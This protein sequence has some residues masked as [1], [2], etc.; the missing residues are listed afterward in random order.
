[1]YFDAVNGL[2]YIDT[3]GEGGTTGSRIALNSW[4]AK[5]AYAD[6][7]EDRITTTYAK[8][9]ELGNYT[10]GKANQLTHTLKF[11]MN[12]EFVFDG[13]QDVTV[14]VYTGSYSTS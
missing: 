9:S 4:G 5:K 6:E 8:L 13:S 10:V 7:N 12:E 1:M 2:F 11:G 14:P 3:S